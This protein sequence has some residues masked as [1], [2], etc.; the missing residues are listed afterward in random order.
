MAYSHLFKI[1]TLGNMGTG[2]TA[3]I[4]SMYQ[5]YNKSKIH[6][7]PTIG[8]DFFSKLYKH[9]DKVIKIHFWDTS[10]DTRYI[11]IINSYI[12]TIDAIILIF[13]VTDKDSFN[14]ILKWVH[15][16]EKTDITIKDKLILLVGTKIDDKNRRISFQEGSELANMLNIRYIECSVLKNI[17]INIIMPFMIDNLYE[18]Y[19][20][21]KGFV[22]FNNSNYKI[23]DDSNSNS[24]SN[25][26]V[27]CICNLFK[28]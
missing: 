16:I 24:N 8:L 13:D 5:K 23:N 26:C 20:N 6:F 9:K 1:L 25:K 19:K 10:G 11:S 15:I 3:L 18:K 21:R 17:N 22:L 12:R 4:N 14:D 27:S 7:D 28:K 2:K